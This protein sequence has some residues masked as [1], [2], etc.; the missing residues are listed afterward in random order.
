LNGSYK[1]YWRLLIDLVVL[2]NGY[3]SEHSSKPF[4][5]AWIKPR[6]LNSQDQ[7]RS[8]ST[9][10]D[11]LRRHFLNFWVFLDCQDYFFVAF[12]L[13]NIIDLNKW[14]MLILSGSES[15]A[16]TNSPRFLAKTVKTEVQIK[17]SML[18]SIKIMPR[19]TESYRL[20]L[21]SLYLAWRHFIFL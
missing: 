1:L 8:R 3:S 15:S 13:G 4:E 19:H 6:G 21:N 14:Y 16:L 7:S 17:V 10:L 20:C 2:S 5:I 18:V 12:G 9:S 11:M